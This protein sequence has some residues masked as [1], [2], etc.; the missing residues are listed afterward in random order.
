METS[1]LIAGAGVAGLSAAY[2]LRDRTS[3]TVVDARERIGGR[4]LTAARDGYR[5]EAGANTIRGGDPVLESLVR[6]LDLRSTRI[7]PGD[8][9]GRRYVAR[10]GCPRPLPT[11]VGDL[12]G[13]DLFTLSGR[14][15][16]LKEPFVRPPIRSP[17][18]SVA[19]FVRRRLG[20]EVLDY[21]VDPFTAGVFAG[22]PEDLVLRHA[23]P[24]L[25]EAVA[26]HGSLTGAGLARLRSGL[27]GAL[28]RAFGGADAEDSRPEEP[29]GRRA[30]F[31]FEDGLEILPRTLAEALRRPVRT[32]HRVT[33]V[34]TNG[35]NRPADRSLEVTV[36]SPEGTTT[37]TADHLL[38]TGPAYEIPELLDCS[39][40]EER[41][42][43][44]VPYPPVTVV[45]LGYEREAVTHPLDGF[46]VLVP[47]REEYRILGA[48]FSSTLAPSAAPEGK[49]LL[50]CFVGGARAPDRAR[51]EDEELLTLVHED[52]QR[53]L[54]VE[55]RPS[56]RCVHR[57]N[58]AIPQPV[59]GHDAVLEAISDLEART[60][61]LHLAG[62]F[63]GG[64]SVPNAVR[65]GW[66]TAGRIE[67]AIDQSA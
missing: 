20:P 21:A 56:F 51:M 40:E 36:R 42:L 27:R 3:V 39:S 17:D 49:V 52:L 24:S 38:F 43:R 6:S 12:F 18:E 50:T 64:I 5:V 8:A 53:L 26:D 47:D 2:R 67:E 14:L 28:R 11:S 57:W 16:L 44:A 19:S 22:R 33:A 31:T 62:S 1:V 13:T 41:V 34:R 66:E 58:R 10:A 7:Y 63:R 29:N 32:G 23:L 30:V 15:R 45:G 55:A 37:V 61:G 65:T 35:K 9:A 48:L 4:I 54:D 59:A 25:Y 60:P 46:G